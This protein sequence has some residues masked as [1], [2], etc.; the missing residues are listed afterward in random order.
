MGAAICTTLALDIYKDRQEAIDNMV[1]RRDT[2]QPIPENV[3]L[4]KD[5]N[6]NVYRHLASQNEELLKEIT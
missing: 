4:Y 3:S 1:R 6:E 2:F 5:I